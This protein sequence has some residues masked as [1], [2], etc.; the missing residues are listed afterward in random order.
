MKKKKTTLHRDIYWVGV[1][2]G[3][4]GNLLW[5]KLHDKN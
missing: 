5:D 1:G 4:L 2:R 3:F